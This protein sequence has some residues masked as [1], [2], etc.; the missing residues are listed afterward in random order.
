MN[1]V[2][3]NE[4]GKEQ[5]KE[6]YAVK[7]INQK[8]ILVSD[9]VQQSIFKFAINPNNY[10]QKAELLACGKYKCP[11][12]TCIDY[13]T[14]SNLIYATFS[15]HH[16]LVVFSHDLVVIEKISG[17][18]K[19]PQLVVITIDNIFVLDCQN[20]CIHILTKKTREL[21]KSIIST[22]IEFNLQFDTKGNFIFAD[23]KSNNTDLFT[24]W[25]VT[26]YFQ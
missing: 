16:F 8:E 19:F 2:C 20:P 1:G 17:L 9:L 6:P 4:I 5:L 15:L 13:H 25:T 22:G 11:Y 24:F 14:N 26:A 3:L 10:N 12:V 7:F 21:T 23:G 18:F